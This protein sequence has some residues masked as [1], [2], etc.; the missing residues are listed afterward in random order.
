MIET[1]TEYYQGEVL[2]GTQVKHGQGVYV[3]KVRMTQ[4]TGTFVDGVMCGDTC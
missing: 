4:F 2:P 3:D 1:E